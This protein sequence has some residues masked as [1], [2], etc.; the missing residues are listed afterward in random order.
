[1]RNVLS[2]FLLSTIVLGLSM[3]MLSAQTKQPA[4]Q[5]LQVELTSTIKA[6]KAKVGD[7]VAAI[8]RAPITLSQGLVIPADSKVTGHVRQ[9]EADSADAHTSWIA[10][11]F[12]EIVLKNGQKVPLNCFVRAALSPT[13]T[14]TDP[15]AGQNSSL[16]TPTRGAGNAGMGGATSVGSSGGMIAGTATANGDVGKT[17]TAD[18]QAPVVAHRGQVIGMPGV[19]LQVVDPGHVSVFKSIHKNLELS[20]GLQLM[21]DVRQ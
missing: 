21:L 14:G 12:E 8:T 9:V 4:S 3:T 5:D 19:E 11:S 6:K 16:V 2:S 1:M 7:A 20:E 18:S 15:T 10:L 17:P 13:N